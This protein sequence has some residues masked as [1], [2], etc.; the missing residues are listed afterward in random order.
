MTKYVHGQNL[1]DFMHN[2]NVTEEERATV[3]QKT[4]ELLNKLQKHR[5]SHGDLKHSNILLADK[6]LVLTDLDAMK[7]HR[8]KWTYKMRQVKDVRQAARLLDA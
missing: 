3:R 8:W 7:A 2:S 6:D 5:I 4:L 1:Y